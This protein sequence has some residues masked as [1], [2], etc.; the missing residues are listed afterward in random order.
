MTATLGPAC[1]SQQT[2]CGHSPVCDVPNALHGW[3]KGLQTREDHRA[4]ARPH[5]GPAWRSYLLT[6]GGTVLPAAK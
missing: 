5:S 2:S 6:S 1:L 3:L 4:L